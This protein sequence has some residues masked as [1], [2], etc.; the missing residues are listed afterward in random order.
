[1]SRSSSFLWRLVAGLLLL[2]S[3]VP[4]EPD[5]FPRRFEPDTFMAELQ[6]QGRIRIGIAEDAAPLGRVDGS[7]APSGF[8]VELGR[9]VAD[10][11]HVEPEFITYPSYRLLGLVDVG[12]LDLAF[13]V[14]H[15]SEELVRSYHP[16]DPYLV[17]HQRLLVR[18]S[19][20][21]DDVDDLSGARVC[22]YAEPTTGVDLERLNPGI[23][24]Q[25]A[26]HPRRCLREFRSGRVDAVT[27]EDF[28]LGDMLEKLRRGGSDEVARA[29]IV[30]DDLNTVGYGATVIRGTGFTQFV[31]DVLA[32]AKS[33]GRW[34]RAFERTMQTPP[35]SPPELTLEAAAAL[36]PLD[37]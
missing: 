12:A 9:I 35:Q 4:P 31:R 29:R 1:M 16:T 8:T 10:T 21:W 26:D 30:G 24:L 14:T 37:V 11:L 20:G 34:A 2:A 33:D 7:G 17:A 22:S 6:D 18:P 25:A 19:S 13:P 23:E 32:E 27:A 3:C 36:W 15:L 28:Y 5:P